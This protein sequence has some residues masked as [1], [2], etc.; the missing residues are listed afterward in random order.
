M[1]DYY[2]WK[3]SSLSYLSSRLGVMASLMRFK[4]KI[5]VRQK[6]QCYSELSEIFTDCLYFLCALLAERIL[7]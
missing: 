7:V 4:R 1:P 3:T 6:P 2:T 5:K